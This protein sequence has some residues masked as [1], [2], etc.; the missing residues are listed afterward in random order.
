MALVTGLS[1]PVIMFGFCIDFRSNRSRCD[2][3][4]GMG[5]SFIDKRVVERGNTVDGISPYGEC[6]KCFVA[7]TLSDPTWTSG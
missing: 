7:S 2:R 1:L 3:R 5:A 4:R 6:R